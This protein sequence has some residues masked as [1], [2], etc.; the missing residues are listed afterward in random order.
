MAAN[1][2]N[3]VYHDASLYI[4]ETLMFSLTEIVASKVVVLYDN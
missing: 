1:H 3:V 2:Y 4:H